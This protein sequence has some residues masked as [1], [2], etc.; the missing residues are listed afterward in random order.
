MNLKRFFFVAFALLVAFAFLQATPAKA[1]VTSG[2]IVGTVTDPS[3]AVV[4]GA[5][6]TLK[7][8]AR[9]NTQST[10]TNA[11]GVYQFFLVEPGAYNITVNATGFAAASR[12]INVVLGAPTE[13]SI[14]LSVSGGGTTVTVTE[15]APL[16]Q[17]ENGDVATTLS[18]QQVSQVPNPGNDLSFVAQVAPGVVMN[19]QGGYGNFSSYGMPG[20]SNLFT[21]NGMDDNDPFLNLNN[22]GATN[23]LLGQNEIQE[24]TV[25]QNGYSGTFGEFAGANVNYITKSGGN[26]FHGNAIYYWNG[27]A[28]NAN[29]WFKN[30]DGVNRP[31]DNVNQWAGSFGGPIKKDKL[32]FFFNTEGLRVLLPTSSAVFI[33][34]PAF[35][36]ATISSLVANGLSQSIP[37]Y[38][39]NGLAAP[40][41]PS[42]C[43]STAPVPGGGLGMFNFYNNAN[44]VAG[45]TPYVG[46]S[47]LETFN[48]S[49]GNFTHEWQMAGRG[50]WNVGPNDRAF[51]RFQYDTGTQATI[52][53]PIN[54]LFNTQSIQ[55]EY[56]GQL[57]ETHT[58]NPTLVNQVI[59]S[60]TWYTAIFGNANPAATLAAFPT[61]VITLGSAMT[62]IGGADFAFPQGRNV[63]QYG[64]QDD[65]SKTWNNHTIKW[66]GKFHRND[67]SDHDFGNRAS[68]LILPLGDSAF[69]NGGGALGAPAILQQNF[70]TNLDQP[71]A[72]YEG[73]LYLQ[74]EWRIKSNFTVTADLRAEHPSN[75]VCKHFCLAE[76]AGGDFLAG[77][78]SGPYNEALQPAGVNGGIAINRY[79]ALNGYTNIVWEPRI[80]F[81]WSPFG[82]ASGWMKSNFVVR[83]GF[84]IFSDVFPGLIA[85]SLATNSPLFNSFQLFTGGGNPNAFSP[86]QITG[87]NLFAAAAAGNAAFL[88]VFNSGTGTAPIAPNITTTDNFNKAPRYEK[89]SMEIQKGFGNNTSVSI[90][91]YGNHGYNIP[92][93]NNSLNAFSN[94]G[95]G[96]GVLPFSIP[97]ARFAEAVQAQS[98]GISNYNGATVS[99]QHRFSRFGSGVVQMNY[100]F[101]KANDDV[102]NGGII[103]AFTGASQNSPANPF[104]ISQSYGPADYDVRHYF[105]ANY[106]WEVPVRTMLR[107]H[108]SDYFVK[109]WQLS[110]D[111]FARSGLPWSV[112]DNGAGNGGAFSGNNFF[113]PVYPDIVGPTAGTAS[114][115]NGQAIAITNAGTGVPCILAT[116]FVGGTV[117][118]GN[119]YAAGSE[120]EPGLRGLRNLFR[121]PHY[122]DTDFTVMKYTKIP[123]WEHASLGLGLQFFNLFNHPNFTLPVGDISQAAF[124]SSGNLI[125]NFGKSPNTVS[126]PTSILGSFLGGDASPRLIQFKA[127]F[128]F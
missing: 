39:T 67:I 36:S 79:Q 82:S 117:N 32:F 38:C 30:A 4:P 74:D 109:G 10:K 83:G 80:S 57:V 105:N 45:A 96:V 126:T 70:A 54:S 60:A 64:V 56:Q 44:G 6:V 7:S 42:V 124:D 107:G 51:L 99:F 8:S 46:D 88:N 24:A 87:S 9:G 63:T 41:L 101:S 100:T 5:Q 33:P 17:N 12:D 14:A 58:F 21:I 26:D 1:Q 78:H 122:V 94:G 92:I 91:Y 89:W 75:L 48:S 110:G 115:Q 13:V 119:P 103:G 85:D 23:L 18:Q 20:T 62:G 120:L 71:M 53:D 47:N 40:N 68:G 112:V 61:T 102:S 127:E 3:G 114:C 59:L 128:K 22:S 52:T 50:D 25:V 111:F 55:P 19:T 73:G 27:R 97:D 65:F 2:N 49:A 69:Q 77:T 37:F 86:T 16:T 90:G 66:G 11:G 43:A 81:A 28:M 35:E 95:F 76:F 84:G 121:G 29:D 118:P 34:T 104:N 15:A 106:V 123:G 116:G 93:F 108:G 98:A 113:G 72:D 31:F 125:G